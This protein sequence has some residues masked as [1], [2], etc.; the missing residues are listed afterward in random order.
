[1]STPLILLTTGT[2]H[3]SDSSNIINGIGVNYVD[4]VC[5]ANG[6]PV[7][8]PPVLDKKAIRKAVESAD[9]ILLTGGGDILPSIYGQVQ[10]PATN[11]INEARDKAEIEAAIAALELKLPVLG[12]CRG[13]QILNVALGGTL[14]QDIPS[15]V[16]SSIIHRTTSNDGY[17]SHKVCVEKGSILHSIVEA[18][19][20]TVNS[21][22]HQALK[23]LGRG[24]S[25]TA[26][27]D[28]GI[29][30]AVELN[31]C[32]NVLGVQWHPEKIF[33]E[34]PLFKKFFDWLVSTSCSK[35]CI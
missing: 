35:A 12:I 18:D 13:I 9:G 11:E 5:E 20:F 4:A 8:V 17:A 19:S 2:Y 28:D 34:Q 3:V 32:G 15:Q 1:M 25:V 22:H 21:F 24:L 23:K 26:K 16:S 10:N 6:A 14:I 30:E 29:I 27:S 7:M 33:S 31:S